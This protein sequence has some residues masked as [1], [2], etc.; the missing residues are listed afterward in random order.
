[1]KIKK[2]LFTSCL[3][4]L[5]AFFFH[6]CDEG[7]AIVD[8]V[9]ANTE[10]GAILRTVNLISNEL[11]LGQE[12]ANFSVEV[13]VQDVESGDLV[14]TIE[15]YLGFRDN[16]VEEGGTDLDKDEI[17]ITTLDVAS[18]SIGEFGFP[19]TT[20]TITVPE[21]LAALGLDNDDIDGSDQFTIRFELVLDDGRR[22]SFANNSGTLT[23]SFFSSPFLYTPA[24][25]CL[26]E[27][28]KE[29]TYVTSN[30][31]GPFAAGESTTGED[32]FVALTGTTYTTASGF[33]DF[34]YYC[35]V[36][37]GGAASDCG[38][39]AAG[40]L[41]I[42]DTCGTLS[43]LGADQFGDPWEIYDVSVSGDTLTFTWESAYGEIATVAL[44]TKD[45]SDWE[46][47]GF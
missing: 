21:M 22:Y 20:Y 47:L 25:V 24:V 10:R 17:L 31:Q 8:D 7:D 42:Q 9:T 33:F 34:G 13:E 45:G 43:F 5:L 39:G 15:V 11:P 28:A 18:F 41:E 29:F 32:A 19:R 40:T 6:A 23:G 27:L 35:T 37:N 14:N 26:S 38:D 44:T 46:L 16:T 3:T 30:M 12:D 2:L 36:Y 4:V 1:M